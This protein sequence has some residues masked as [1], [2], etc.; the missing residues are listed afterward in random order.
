M[1]NI[2]K[3]P[4][5]ILKKSFKYVNSNTNA[6]DSKLLQ[7][8]FRKERIL[9]SEMEYVCCFTANFSFVKHYFS[10]LSFL[11]YHIVANRRKFKESER[12]EKIER[13]CVKV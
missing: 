4:V 11:N 10:R 6:A 1:L 3:N 5:S 12:N 8:Y 9:S 7:K 13:N 2:N